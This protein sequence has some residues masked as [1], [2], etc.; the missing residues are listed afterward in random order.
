MPSAFEG[1]LRPYQERG[2]AWLRFL[3]RWGLGACLAK[4]GARQTVQTLALILYDREKPEDR[5]PVLLVCPTSVIG[6]WQRE[7][8]RFTPDLAV[9]V[10]MAAPRPW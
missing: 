10:R 7:A 9:M 5:A 2:Y 4:H 8:A 6:N 1:E 3:R